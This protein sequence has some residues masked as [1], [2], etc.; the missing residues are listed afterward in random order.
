MP[1]CKRNQAKV[2]SITRYA[3][4]W[5]VDV[6]RADHMSR[7]AHAIGSP[8]HTNL[9]YCTVFWWCY[10]SS[11]VVLCPR[12]FQIWRSQY[13]Y[14]LNRHVTGRRRNAAVIANHRDPAALCQAC[15]CW[16]AVNI[17]RVLFIGMFKLMTWVIMR[18]FRRTTSCL[19]YEMVKG[20][21]V[22]W[23]GLDSAASLQERAT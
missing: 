17:S 3:K 14:T 19:I 7:Q 20:V 21:T 13:H 23:S 11:D 10:P 2:K 15:S 22:F 16:W 9:Q 8:F 5:W 1:E 4:A 6:C 18:S 12:R